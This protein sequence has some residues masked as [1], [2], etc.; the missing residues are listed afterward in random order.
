[1]VPDPEF[2][3]VGGRPCADCEEPGVRFEEQTAD[4]TG[5]PSETGRL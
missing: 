4:G 5:Y 1:M 2:G 3:L